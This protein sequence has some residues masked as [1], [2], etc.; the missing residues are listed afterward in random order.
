ML[1]SGSR[2]LQLKKSSE[3]QIW[4]CKR[5][6]HS[7]NRLHARQQPQSQ[8]AS[9]K[10]TTDTPLSPTEA[11]RQRF[12][13]GGESSEPPKQSHTPA[14]LFRTNW[15]KLPPSERPTPPPS[16]TF[17]LGDL[18]EAYRKNSPSSKYV[19]RDIRT[20]N[21]RSEDATTL[22][23]VEEA[24]ELQQLSQMDD[25][26]EG[27]HEIFAGENMRGYQ[28]VLPLNGEEYVHQRFFIKQGSLIETR[29]YV[30]TSSF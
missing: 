10:S 1:S 26:E 28:G 22:E 29:G 25:M 6:L 5:C 3:R 12:A 8:N 18:A 14:D 7:Q 17:T 24:S 15:M 19:K 30:P 16:N 20:T 4:I 9:S 2:S 23:E 13:Q 11:F 21:P 27:S